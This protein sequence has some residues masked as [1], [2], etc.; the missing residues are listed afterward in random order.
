MSTKI[1]SAN[2]SLIGYHGGDRLYF[3]PVTKIKYTEGVKELAA[4]TESYWFLD[5]IASYQYKMKNED[6][7][8]WKL[9]RELSY[10]LVN[11]I[12]NV[13]QR[14]NCFNVVCEDGNGRV[15]IQ[16]EIPFSDFEFDTYTLWYI[17]QVLLLPVEY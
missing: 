13:I 4:K 12:K 5:L 17:N 15:L 14:K 6:F 11:G 3:N 1:Q 7:Q 10:T 8:V 9:E 2:D 16:Q